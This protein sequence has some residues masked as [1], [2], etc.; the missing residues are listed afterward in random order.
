MISS[1]SEL[2]EEA[3]AETEAEG[4]RLKMVMTTSVVDF[5]S[6][7]RAL[8]SLNEV[9]CWAGGRSSS[10]LDTEDDVCDNFL[11]FGRSSESDGS[12]AG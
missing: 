1:S 5:D 6:C 3:E 4:A 7:P 2:R 11:R 10:L 9:P 12:V 8:R